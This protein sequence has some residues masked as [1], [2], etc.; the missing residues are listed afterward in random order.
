MKHGK[1]NGGHKTGLTAQS[2]HLAAFVKKKVCSDMMSNEENYDVE[3]SCEI[4]AGY[5]A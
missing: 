5:D 2:K 4:V 3:L 1:Q